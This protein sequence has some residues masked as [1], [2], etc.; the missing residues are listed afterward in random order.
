MPN[1][2]ISKLYSDLYMIQ[3]LYIRICWYFA[4]FAPVFINSAFFVTLTARAVLELHEMIPD[5]SL[6][7]FLLSWFT[8]PFQ[9][10]I[11]F[12]RN[13]EHHSHSYTLIGTASWRFAYMNRMRIPIRCF[14]FINS[15]LSLSIIMWEGFD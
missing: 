10:Q 5:N 6:F 12:R 14:G 1:K 8:T 7:L 13:L 15:Y 3:R 11:I 9:C 2:R 4:R